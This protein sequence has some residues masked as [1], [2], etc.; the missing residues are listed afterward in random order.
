MPKELE[1]LNIAIRF[2]RAPKSKKELGLLFDKMRSL[3]ESMK[4]SFNLPNRMIEYEKRRINFYS[5]NSGFS[6]FFER[7]ITIIGVI[8]NPKKNIKVANKISNKIINFTS[9][10]IGESAKY[11]NVRASKKHFI[12]KKSINLA[13]KMLGEARI[14]KINEATKLTLSPLMIAFEYKLKD[15]ENLIMQISND[16]VG[17]VVSSTV[18]YKDG[19][20]FDFLSIINEKLDKSE[21]IIKKLTTVEL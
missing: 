15:Y 8:E 11:A 2:T 5:K 14:A 1:E 9:T 21:K 19:I 10:V 12:P 18:T 16:K 17:Y 7:P 20:P 13:K 4:K 3:V 6:V